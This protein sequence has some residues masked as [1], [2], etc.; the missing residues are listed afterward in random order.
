MAYK[1]LIFGID[2]LYEK[3]KPL[4]NTAVK[5]GNI[6]IVATA[7]LQ[8]DAVKLVYAD[9]RHGKPEDI[10][11]FELALVSSKGDFYRR[12]KQLE[13]YGVPREKI[14]DGRVFQMP[15]LDFPRFIAEGCLLRFGEN[16]F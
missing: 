16:Y 5:N 2:N 8:K 12:M 15:N 14:I 3:L 11:N 1:A 10:P 13:A 7:E 6:E 4:Y 9:G